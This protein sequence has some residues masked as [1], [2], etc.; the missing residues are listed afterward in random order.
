MFWP[1]ISQKAV[2]CAQITKQ[3]CLTH[4]NRS[5]CLRNV[6]FISCSFFLTNCKWNQFPHEILQSFSSTYLKHFS[7]VQKAIILHHEVLSDIQL[8]VWHIFLM[9]Q[10]FA[11]CAITNVNFS[12]LQDSSRLFLY[13]TYF[14][15]MRSSSNMV[16]SVPFSQ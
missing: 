1:I 6:T 15:I 10:G 12:N 2:L 16:R 11:S 5:L 9:N 8:L 4:F 3:G 7:S 14:E 13:N